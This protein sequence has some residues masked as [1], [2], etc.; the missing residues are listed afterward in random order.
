MGR[1]GQAERQ[2]GGASEREKER[3][4][5]A[6]VLYYISTVL[7]LPSTT[8]IPR[9]ARDRHEEGVALSLLI[10]LRIGTVGV[11]PKGTGGVA[12]AWP[13]GDVER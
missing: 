10:G 13:A 9:G 8:Q 7:C 11:T 5:V 3:D 6:C 4:E 2:R 12:V 1:S